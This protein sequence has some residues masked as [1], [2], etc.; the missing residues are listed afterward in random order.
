M[1]ILNKEFNIQRPQFLKSK[2]ISVLS[3]VHL[4]VVYKQKFNKNLFTQ[5]VGSLIF[6]FLWVLDDLYVSR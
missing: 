5:Y 2:R 1:D 3:W 6:L 4:S